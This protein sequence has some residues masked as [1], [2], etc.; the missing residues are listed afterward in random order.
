MKKIGLI[1]VSD[2]YKEISDNL[3]KN[4]IATLKNNGLEAEIKTVKG[5]LEIPILIAHQIN[6]KI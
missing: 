3:I 5:S 4:C 1:V 6:K 2:Y